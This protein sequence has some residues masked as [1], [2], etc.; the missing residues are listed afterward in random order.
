[1][2][3]VVRTYYD[4]FIKKWVVIYNDP[5]TPKMNEF[6][7]PKEAMFDT[8][9]EAKGFARYTVKILWTNEAKEMK[10]AGTLQ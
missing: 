4:K 1:M 9:N 3:A 8:Q 10:K 2:K 5:R 7:G 6:L